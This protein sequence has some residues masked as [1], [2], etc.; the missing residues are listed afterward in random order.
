MDRAR[1]WRTVLTIHPS[2]LRRISYSPSTGL[3]SKG[4]LHVRK[5]GCHPER[6]SDSFAAL[7]MTA[8]TPDALGEL[9]HSGRAPAP[10]TRPASRTDL[11]ELPAKR[12]PASSR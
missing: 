11:R 10:Y 2:A 1:T 9:G 3:K 4:L 5:E 12:S 6:S 8:R 7:R